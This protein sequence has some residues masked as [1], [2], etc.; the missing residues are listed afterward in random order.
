[1]P[2]WSETREES[3]KVMLMKRKVWMD[4][5]TFDSL[6]KYL[7]IEICIEHADDYNECKVLKRPQ[8]LRMVKDK[9]KNCAM[10]ECAFKAQAKAIANMAAI[11]LKKT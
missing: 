5:G 9:F 11:T 2:R 10:R 4:V 7:E 1:V 3:K 6:N 8:G